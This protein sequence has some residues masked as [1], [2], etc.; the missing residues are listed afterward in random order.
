MNENYPRKE[1]D[2]E[3]GPC[4]VKFGLCTIAGFPDANQEGDKLKTICRIWLLQNPSK[5]KSLGEFL[6]KKLRQLAIANKSL[7]NV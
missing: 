3:S 6:I 1:C 7:L 4:V 5:L 2:S